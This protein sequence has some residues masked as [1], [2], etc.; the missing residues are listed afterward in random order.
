[1]GAMSPSPATFAAHEQ[2][3]LAGVPSLPPSPGIEPLSKPRSQFAARGA[4]AGLQHLPF[5]EKPPTPGNRPSKGWRSYDVLLSSPTKRAIQDTHGPI[6]DS[7]CADASAP[8]PPR[9]K[10]CS[11]LV[12]PQQVSSRSP[13]PAQPGR[14]D[15]AFM[16]VSNQ[17]SR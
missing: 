17:A 8:L 4:A 3:P 6:Q 7:S 2:P 9:P 14:S 12:R 16:K 5:H 13:I 1:M 15:V 11:I 10:I